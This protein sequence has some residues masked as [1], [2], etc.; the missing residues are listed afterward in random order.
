MED[1]WC[2]HVIGEYL[3]NVKNMHG[4]GLS[5]EK[6]SEFV[7]APQDQVQKI[8]ETNSDSSNW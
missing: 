4:A 3:L 6:I 8:I 5:I 2:F 7:K 1:G